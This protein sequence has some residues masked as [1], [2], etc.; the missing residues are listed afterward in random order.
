METNL[1]V[2]LILAHLGASFVPWIIVMLAGGGLGYLLATLLRRWFQGHPR[3]L[4][5]MVLLPWRSIAMWIALVMIDTPWMIWVFGLG[6]RSTI[7]AIGMALAALFVPWMTSA[8]LHGWYPASPLRQIG[9]V[10]RTS[11]ILAIVLPVF[12]QA[13]MGYFIDRVSF[14]L[15][16]SKMILGYEVL[17]M[18]MVGVDLIG[19]ILLLIKGR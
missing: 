18:M 17:G 8:F 15:D 7:I 12:L 13:G 10:V 4:D 2:A 19:G 11:A 6:T 5:L 14:D 16:T 9:S 1:T 3:A